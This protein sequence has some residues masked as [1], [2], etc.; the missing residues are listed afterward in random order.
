MQNG[1]VMLN[2]SRTASGQHLGGTLNG[3]SR[4]S[5]SI[6]PSVTRLRLF[7]P[8]RGETTL[9]FR[10]GEQMNCRIWIVV[11]P[12]LYLFP[13]ASLRVDAYH[14]CANAE[15]TSTQKGGAPTPS[16]KAK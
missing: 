9:A 13:L 16:W 10:R 4:N 12:L 11:N 6:F 7:W 14:F 5:F 1:Q 8:S 15:G 3:A 2:E